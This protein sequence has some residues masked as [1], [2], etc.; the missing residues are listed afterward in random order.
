MLAFL[1]EMT[2]ASS[3]NMVAIKPSM[4]YAELCM[5]MRLGKARYSSGMCGRGPFLPCIVDRPRG[6]FG[7]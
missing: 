6:W 1:T 3:A 4:E 2:Q 5:R 7:Q